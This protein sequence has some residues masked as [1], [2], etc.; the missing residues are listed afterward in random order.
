MKIKND[1]APHPADQHARRQNQEPDSTERNRNQEPTGVHHPVWGAIRR[2]PDGTIP[3]RCRIALPRDR[4]RN[5]DLEGNALIIAKCRLCGTET[6]RPP[7]EKVFYPTEADT[8]AIAK[9]ASRMTHEKGGCDPCQA[10]MRATQILFAARSA[11]LSKDQE[12]SLVEGLF[13]LDEAEWE[14]LVESYCGGLKALA[15]LFERILIQ[16]ETVLH[17]LFRNK[18]ETADQRRTKFIEL[19]EFANTHGH[20]RYSETGVSLEVS[21]GL[22]AEWL[23][24][25]EIDLLICRWLV[26]ARQKQI[27]TLRR[28]ASAKY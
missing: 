21:P 15:N 6:T 13:D 9:L 18:T 17:N 26:I 16:M 8:V 19:I 12:R 5:R 2:Y 1:L 28:Q 22:A 25:G 23:D 7:L 4:H 10:V 20:R 24:S 14:R 3:E 11:H 27:A